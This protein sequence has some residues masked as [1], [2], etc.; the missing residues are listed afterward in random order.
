MIY[1]SYKLLQCTEEL[2]TSNFNLK[3]A[4]PLQA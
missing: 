1:V 4:K 3:N 2:I